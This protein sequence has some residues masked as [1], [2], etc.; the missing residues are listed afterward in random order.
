[1][2]T[3]PVQSLWL[4]LKNKQ[5]TITRCLKGCKM[6]Y[7]SQDKTGTRGYEKGQPRSEHELLGTKYI[8]DKINNSINQCKIKRQKI[9][10]KRLVTLE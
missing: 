2:F 5:P 7:S 3:V 8:T 6:K 10:E 9:Q 4:T 1:M